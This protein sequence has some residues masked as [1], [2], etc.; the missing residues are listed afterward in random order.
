MKEMKKWDLPEYEIEIRK[1][2]VS[3]YLK[4]GSVDELLKA[5]RFS[6]PM[7]EMSIH[8]VIKDWG[9]VKA[10]GPNRPLGEIISFFVKLTEKKVPLEALY[11]KMP[12]S[13]TPA[14]AN[15]HRIYKNLKENV[16]RRLE[17]RDLRRSATALVIT[18]EDDPKRILVGFDV[19]PRKELGK[20]YGAVSLPMGFSRRTE[21]KEVSIL[22]VLQQEVFMEMV[23]ERKFP[24]ELL[25]QNPE[26]FMY[27]DVADIRVAVYSMV[28]P[29]EFSDTKSFSS[30]KLKKHQFLNLDNLKNFKEAHVLRVGLAE[31]FDGYQN[32]LKAKRQAKVFTPLYL[33][34]WLNRELE[35]LILGSEK[36]QPQPVV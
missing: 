10:A 5:N 34:S 18:P 7:S 33:R 8:R 29:G 2:V 15:L 25:P 36:L 22:R 26:P 24:F 14:V 11:T 28:L 19:S 9:I 20:P 17:E 4:Y 30:H 21:P 6:I 12:P 27:V 35:E 16:K 1:H 31:I 3:E 32:F 13:F 23:I